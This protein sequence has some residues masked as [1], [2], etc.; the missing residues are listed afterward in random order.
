MSDRR[1]APPRE[2]TAGEPFATRWSRLKAQ[3]RAGAAPEVAAGPEV[4]PP[5]AAETA[6]QPAPPTQSPEAP[7]PGPA[8]PELPDIESLGEDS[9]YSNFL[10]EGVDA[11]LRR[12]AL[13]KLF[14][15]PKFNVLDGLDDYMGDYTQFEPL[16]SVV[17]A[18]MR[19]HLERAARLAERALD[20]G[21]GSEERG[22]AVASVPPDPACTEEPAPEQ[23]ESDRPA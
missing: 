17:T 11:V 14:H 12:R 18:D 3:A 19:H 4:K 23:D 13:R 21:D 8:P 1:P 22:D 2:D 20:Q 5:P 7:S 9:D 6:P 16:G 15:S 10:A